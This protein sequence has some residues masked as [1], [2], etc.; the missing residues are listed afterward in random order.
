MAEYRHA[1]SLTSLPGWKISSRYN[2]NPKKFIRCAHIVK[3]QSRHNVVKYKFG[4]HVPRT[5][6]EPYDIYHHNRKQKCKEEI[7]KEIG[8]ILDYETSDILYKGYKCI[9][10]HLCWL[11]G[12]H[13]EDLPALRTS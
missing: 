5:I 9:P 13:M 7:D 10:S 1:N 11:E 2:K 8:K 12:V 4:I 3:A 6:K